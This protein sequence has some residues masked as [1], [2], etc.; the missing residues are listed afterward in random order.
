M[1]KVE[2]A[3]AL[4]LKEAVVI[5]NENQERTV[6]SVCKKCGFTVN[7]SKDLESDYFPKY[8]VGYLVDDELVVSLKPRDKIEAKGYFV[9]TVNQFSKEIKG[10]NN[11][12]R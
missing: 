8:A 1:N 7:L 12:K 6:R 5:E 2:L 3:Q 11:E 10:E 4:L 9:I